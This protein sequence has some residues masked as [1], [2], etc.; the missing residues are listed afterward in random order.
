MTT[1]TISTQ[2]TNSTRPSQRSV[3]EEARNN[4]VDS[5]SPERPDQDLVVEALDGNREMGEGWRALSASETAS[6]ASPS[7]DSGRDGFVEGLYQGLL[8]RESDAEG[9]E[10]HSQD[11][12]RGV[13]EADVVK[14]FVYSEEYAGQE[15]SP[16]ETVADLYRTVLGRE[17]DAGGANHFAA[18]GQE[19][20]WASVVDS[21]FNSDEYRAKNQAPSTQA[22]TGSDESIQVAVID[23]FVAEG[24][25]F[26]HGQNIDEIIT[27]GGAIR[28][29]NVSQ[30]APNIETVRFNI[31]HTNGTGGRT[32]NIADSL[33]AV[34][35]QASNG[36]EFD[37]VN[38]SQQD[39][40]ASQ[41]T[42]EV[43]RAIQE[44]QS[45]FGI[46]V[47]VAAGNQGA[48]ARNQLAPAAAFQVANSDFGSEFR[49]D[50]SGLGN[51][52]SEGEF[53]SQATANVTARVAQLHAQGLTIPEIQAAIYQESL[54]EGGALDAMATH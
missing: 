19:K 24:N 40:V 4:Q 26:N 46:P 36:V 1:T 18:Q 29:G 7:G 3:S 47:V 6:N 11:L 34:I 12:A 48:G 14:N 30:E 28:N 2:N 27:A 49:A 52:L 9:K 45:A 44:L 35:D 10:F 13:S 39:F 51:V 16:Q 54:A 31:D 20:G 25:G 32:Q 38:I 50:M 17:P 5:T 15:K 37:A 33:N 42:A 41:D 23:D 21:L 53:T 8:G 22:N 43:T